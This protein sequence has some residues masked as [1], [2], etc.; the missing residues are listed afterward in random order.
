MAVVLAAIGVLAAAGSQLEDSPGPAGGAGARTPGTP[1]GATLTMAWSQAPGSLDPAFATDTTSANLAWNLFDPLVRLGPDLEPVPAAAQSWHVSED[2]QTVT[3]RLRG[4]ARWTNGGRVTARD[5][6]Y[7]WKRVLSPQTKSPL[8]ERLYGIAGAE[9]YHT[10]VGD[11]C[12]RLA[13]RLGI[14]AVDARTLAVRLRGPRPW[15]VAETAH[16]AFLPVHASTVERY[17]EDWT[18]PETI[19]TNGPFVLESAGEETITLV[20]NRRFRAAALVALGRVVGRIVPDGRARV[21]AF[22]SGE[23]MALDGGPLPAADLPALR[24]R[25]E[26]EAYPMLGSYAYAFNLKSIRDVHQRRAMA[27]AID[28]NAILANV[29]QQDMSPAT[30]FTPSAAP[31]FA[32]AEDSPWL[33]ADGALSVARDE[34]GRAAAVEEQVTLLHVDAPGNRA[35]A[36]AVRDAWSELGIETTLRARPAQDFLAFRGPLSRE[37]VDLYQ[38]ELHYPFADAAPGL[39][40]WACAADR[41]K[42]GFCRARFD[43]LLVRASREEDPEIRRRLYVRAEQILSGPTGALPAVPIYWHTSANLETLAVQ[44]TFE[45]NALGQIDLAAVRRD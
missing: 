14:R 33:P 45:V 34:L 44:E 40:V 43:A 11:S 17:G 16:T 37:S 25:R 6:A 3:F 30:R 9:A 19:V 12:A 15:F 18:E 42:S 39:A 21:Q 8:A 24:E 27:L 41:N 32:Q 36:L 10:C 7:A 22:D 2:G 35:L 29:V 20:K 26:Y 28:R 38:V 31:G 4:D 23:V 13:D 1:A 5:Y